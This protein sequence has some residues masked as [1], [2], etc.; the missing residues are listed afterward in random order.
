M[1]HRVYTARRHPPSLLDRL[2]GNPTR[3]RSVR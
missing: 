1:P 3:D 2:L